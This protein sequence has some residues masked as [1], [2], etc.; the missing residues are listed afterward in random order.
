M[1]KKH[2][3]IVI[4]DEPQALSSAQMLIHEESSLFTCLGVYAGIEEALP[5]VLNKKI[6]LVLCDIE[7]SDGII[8]YEQLEKFP[9]TTAII[10]TTGRPSQILMAS[11]KSVKYSNV[12]G[13]LYK[14]LLSNNIIEIEQIYSSYISLG[15]AKA[16][17]SFK[18][19]FEFICCEMSI[20]E[21]RN[22]QI[23]LSDI[24]MCLPCCENKGCIVYLLSTS[25]PMYINRVNMQSLF[26]ELDQK[27]SNTF[28]LVGRKGIVNR[29]NVQLTQNRLI[30]SI[31][32]Y[33]TKGIGIQVPREL[34][35]EVEKLINLK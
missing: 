30:P 32:K 20:K 19:K 2:T 13:C 4:D 9:T 8:D 5:F 35:L 18:N 10:F 6:D 34:L 17:E 23:Y 3:C 24:I 21:H 7:I 33:A 15:K 28:I 16:V 11:S 22:I 25:R 12:I 29:K 1:D 14:P 27:I 31:V 26:K